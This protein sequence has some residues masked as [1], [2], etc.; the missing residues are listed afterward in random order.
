MK[1]D[2]YGNVTLRIPSRTDFE[3]LQESR[4]W[5][6]VGKPA[7]LV[8]HPCSGSTEVTLWDLLRE[9][10]PNEEVFLVNR[11]DR[12]TSGCV[13][14][15][16]SGKAARVLGKIL[17][18]GEAAKKYLAIVHGWPEWDDCRVETGL[19]RKGEF[20]PSEIWVRQAVHPEGKPSITRFEVEQR[21]ENDLG[22]FSQIRCFP[23]SGRTHQIRVHLE[24]VGHGIVG[25]K[26]YGRDDSAYLR[27][28]D[29]GW[30]N[31][32]A[33]E[34]LLPRQALHAARL[35]FPWEGEQ[36]EVRCRLPDDLLS[37]GVAPGRDVAFKKG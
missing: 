4:D 2:L 16:R 20:T 22:R 8:V 24:S 1:R 10:R 34:L 19:R 27:F 3:I 25:D 14:V 36:V 30:S 15:A 32:L 23:E 13:L 12:E 11:L 21:W 17:A 18:R 33:D 35:S 29:E 6:V 5:L 26:I 28:L 9:S 37:F 31:S 7:P